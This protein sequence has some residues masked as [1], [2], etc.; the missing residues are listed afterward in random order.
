MK[1]DEL[2]SPTIIVITDRTELDG[3]I[4]EDFENAK[5]YLNE[6]IVEKIPSRDELGNRLRNASG[7]G[8]FTTTV[9]KFTAELGLLSDRSNIVCICDEA[10]R[11]QTNVEEKTTLVYNDVNGKA[12]E[13]VG[14]KKSYGFAKYLRDSFPNAT[15][16]GFSGT[17]IDG[18]IE[19]FGDVVSTYSMRDS[20]SDEITVPITYEGRFAEVNLSDEMTKK[21][22]AYYQQCLEVEGSN[23]DQVDASKKEMGNLAQLIGNPDRLDIIAKDLLNHY[24]VRVHEGASVKGKTMIVCMNRE[25]AYEL[26]KRI[27]ELRPEL[28]EKR[29]GAIGEE[30]TENDEENLKPI[31]T[32]KMVMT[33]NKDK[34]TPELWKMLG[35][36]EHREE[37][38][39]AFKNERS[40]FKIAIVVDM[41]ITGFDVPCLDTMYIDRPLKKHTLV[42]TIS[43]VNRKF[44]GK[45]EGLIVDYFNIQKSLIEALKMYKG[46][47]EPEGSGSNG[48][49]SGLNF[50]ETAVAIVLDQLDLLQR[51]FGG[52]DSSR[53]FGT[54]ELSM[55]KCLQEAREYVLVSDEFKRTFD[56]QVKKM[57]SAYNLCTG[58]K[59][60][61]KT[62]R[63]WIHFFIS[64]KAVI[65]KYTQGDAPDIATMNKYVSKLIDQAISADGVEQIIRFKDGE[66]TVN[67]FD[68]TYL[69]QIDAIEMPN[70]KILLLERLLKEQ[71]AKYKKVNQIKAIEFSEKLRKLIDNYNDRKIENFSSII[72]SVKQGMIELFNEISDDKNSFERMGISFE[73]KAIFDILHKVTIDFKEDFENK[74]PTEEKLIEL[75]K[76]IKSAVEDK[77][78]YPYWEDRTDIV[79]KLHMDIARILHKN[80]FPPSA[81]KEAYDQV[82]LQ[83]TYY[84]RAMD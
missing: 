48:G 47:E 24:D 18:T 34:D 15:Y 39:V 20:V 60:L 83:A 36:E 82:L 25:I 69:E 43:R 71:I 46:G 4:A 1:D 49:G 61:T 17:P 58:S 26:Y 68:K 19:V 30:L 56:A 23:P 38:S 73:E 8:I 29:K 62:H 67:I 11:T 63:D 80:G 9:Q 55:I 59:E 70:T 13:V 35:T 84:R 6:E 54:D 77:R 16:V 45:E 33:R 3:Q 75:A 53:Y 21:I 66:S 57:R 41:W 44:V 22:E 65:F 51:S 64:V 50:S 31:E 12:K 37:W 27:I 79:A 5:K 2:N 14:V 52:F 28:Q 81:N 40:N 72:E 42:Q 7:G 74:I 32:I 76:Q 78:R 10:H